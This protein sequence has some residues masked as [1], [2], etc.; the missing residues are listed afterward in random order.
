MTG[1]ETRANG[2]SDEYSPFTRDCGDCIKRYEAPNRKWSAEI[3]SLK[4]KREE[5]CHTLMFDARK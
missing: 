2:P 4:K 5:T 3:L 1:M